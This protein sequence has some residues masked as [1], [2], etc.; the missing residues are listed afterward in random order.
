MRG[1]P[2]QE[3]QPA[4]MAQLLDRTEQ[5]ID[6]RAVQG[7]KTL[8]DEARVYQLLLEHRP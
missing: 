4:R 8:F 5:H 2:C 1:V 6:Y 7:T 3:F